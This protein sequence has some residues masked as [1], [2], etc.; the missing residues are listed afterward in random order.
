MSSTY[1]RT[2]IKNFLTT[3]APTETFIDLTARFEDI[4]DLITD[5]GLDRMDPWIGLQFVG[6]EEIPITIGADNTKG[7]Y[8]ELG[9]VF[10]HIVDVAKL[11]VG[12]TILGRAETLRGLLR[13][14]RVG[15]LFIESVSP[16]N[17]EPG[18][19]LQ[20]EAGYMSA[21]FIATYTNDV[22]L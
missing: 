18:A 20:F 10:I 19:T 7:K 4:E 15:T 21:S 12:D 6:N 5:A 11:G 9:A 22:D 2:Q 1:V 8:R 13:G 17:F 14:R 3:I 16:P